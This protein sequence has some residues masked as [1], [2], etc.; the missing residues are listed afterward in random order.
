M[1]SAASL[2][3]FLEEWDGPLPRG[4]SALAVA[5]GITLQ[6]P[7]SLPPHTL[8]AMRQ[9]LRHTSLAKALQA[10]LH[11]SHMVM[12]HIVVYIILDLSLHL[13]QHVEQLNSTPFCNCM[14]LKCIC[15]C[16]HCYKSYLGVSAMSL[17]IVFIACFVNNGSHCV[18]TVSHPIMRCTMTMSHCMMCPRVVGDEGWLQGCIG[19]KGRHRLATALP[20]EHCL[21]PQRWSRSGLYSAAPSGSST[22]C[23][24]ALLQCICSRP[25]A[26]ALADECTPEVLCSPAAAARQSP[27]TSQSLATA[28]ATGQFSTA[29]SSP[30]QHTAAAALSTTS[31]CCDQAQRSQGPCTAAVKCTSAAGRRRSVLCSAPPAFSPATAAA[32]CQRH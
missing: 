18:V 1:S 19:A 17:A 16:I 10:S 20:T 23:S 11:I 15:S 4:F 3:P 25:F 5:K 27:T 2:K 9:D 21:S 14:H 28:P 30:G 6:Q 32:W 31:C 7:F 12:A 22:T 8:Q 26:T 24:C 13:L 29:A